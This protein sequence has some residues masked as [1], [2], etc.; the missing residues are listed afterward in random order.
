MS[1]E[2]EKKLQQKIAEICPAD[3]DSMEAAKAHWRTVGKPLN[4]LGKLEEAVVR[5]AGI[6][7]KA[8][9][10]IR[11]KGLVIMCADNGV[12]AEGVT[13]TGQEVTAIVAENF[14]RRA[15]SVCL[16][17]EIAGVELFPV[18]IGMAVDVPAVTKPE[19]KVMSGTKDMLLEPAMTREQAAQAVLTG[20]H[21]VEKLAGQG[22][23]LLATG[24]MGIGNT[25]TSSAVAAVLLERDA[26][27]VTGRGAGLSSEGL[28]RKIDVIRRS[29]ELHQPDK[30]DVLDVL[31]KV[32]G[33]DIAGLA[34]VFLGG[35][36]E[37]LPV[38]MDGFISAAAALLACRIAPG[39]RDYIL[40]SHMSGEPGME[41]ILKELGKEAFIGC[42]M[43]LGE[44]TGAVALMPLLDMTLEVYRKMPDFDG[45][46]I[47]AYTP[48]GGE[49]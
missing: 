6:R 23:D 48:L 29:I 46:Q 26:A 2:F 34:G 19:Y 41:R 38:V 17:A 14:T 35:A 39:V 45:I 42:H 15:T 10:T 31:S 47:E 21:M 49:A 1:E 44:G 27:E 12:V 8:D 13:Q 25:T 5:M 30:E 37:H 9:Y 24:E 28:N 16:M 20:I 4:S 32:G 18:D 40:P 7:G 22:Y 43:K 3:Q 33:L 11:K 36:M